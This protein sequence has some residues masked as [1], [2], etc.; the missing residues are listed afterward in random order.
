MN[1][2]QRSTSSDVAAE[3]RAWMGRRQRSTRSVALELG[4]T[5]TYLGRR[6]KGSISFTVAEL[7]ALADL[8]EVP[9]EAFFEIPRGIR[10]PGTFTPT[11]ELEIAA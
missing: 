2:A 10:I 1:L 6:L 3:V 9:I 8:L 7:A 4:M 11:N 5:E